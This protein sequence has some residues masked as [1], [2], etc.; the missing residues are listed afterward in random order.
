MLIQRGPDAAR[1]ASCISRSDAVGGEPAARP[2]QHKQKQRESGAMRKMILRVLAVVMLVGVACGA[3]AQEA[4]PPDEDQA[5]QQPA[6]STAE[7]APAG[8]TDSAA[9]PPTD[10][11][12]TAPE[13]AAASAPSSSSD[14][15]GSS[16]AVAPY[17]R[18][19]DSNGSFTESVAIAVPAFHG[20]E[21]PLTLSYDSSHGNGPVG[22]GWRL[23]GLSVIERSRPHGGA[24]LFDDAS[25][26][27]TLDG[28]EMTACSSLPAT[29]P[30]VPNQTTVPSCPAGGTHATRIES[31]LRIK[32]VTGTPNQWEVT[33]RDGTK[34]I[35]KAVSTW[36]TYGADAD[37]V[38]RATNFRWLLASVIDTHSGNNS[39]NSAAVQYGY[40]CDGVP[41]CYIDTIT[42]NGNTIRFYKET[43]TDPVWYATGAGLGKINFRYKTIDVLVSGQRARAYKLSY[44]AGTASGR[45]RLASAQQFGRDATFDGTNTI[46]GGAS[47]PPITFAYSDAAN[48]VSTTSWATR[49]GAWGDNAARLLGDF[50]G[51]G[52]TDSFTKQMTGTCQF[53]L[54]LSNGSGF[55]L[56]QWTVTPA[57]GVNCNPYP[58]PTTANASWRSGDFNGDGKSDVMVF[59]CTRTSFT[60]YVY[61][62]TGSGFTVSK[63]ANTITIRGEDGYQQTAGDFNGD[64]NEDVFIS[65]LQSVIP[66]PNP[67]GEATYPDCVGRV[68]ISTGSAFQISGASVPS[69]KFVFTTNPN[70][71]RR[72]F[73]GAL[74]GDGDGDGKVDLLFTRVTG[75]FDSEG[76][77]TQSGTG[78]RA[79]LG[80]ADGTFTAAGTW[81]GAATNQPIPQVAGALN[82]DGRDDAVKL[83]SNGNVTAYLSTGAKFLAQSTSVKPAGACSTCNLRLGD[84]N[85]D[86]MTDAVTTLTGPTT[87]NF[88]AQFSVFTW[89]NGALVGQNWGTGLATS[90]HPMDAVEID[91]DGKTDLL[92]SWNDAGS[93]SASLNRVGG[94]I[95]DL[96]TGVTSSLGGMTTVAYTPS[97]AWANTNLQFVMQTVSS[98][99]LNDGR[100]TDSKTDYSYA[101]GLWNAPDRR[102]LGFAS[103]TATLPKNAEDAQPP[104]ITSTFLQNICAHPKP[105]VTD[106]KDGASTILRKTEEEY[107]ACTDGPPYK[108]LHTSTTAT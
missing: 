24:P 42:Y 7:E 46:T 63:W 65:S 71:V 79:Y 75:S 60:P 64:G 93:W 1:S 95:P 12:S 84:F 25:D 9:A 54:R 16:Q 10:D 102:F 30:T 107:T 106:E 41:D 18:T 104:T 72:F 57:T 14:D 53:G 39:T 13:A 48:T 88:T 32:R 87:A 47:L 29:G 19:I 40:V 35:Y 108:S 6:G 68:A 69:C 21:P 92:T 5:A 51:D 45:S 4:P 62:S 80:N 83:E 17:E 59:C 78:L 89:R 74:T 3:R 11:A 37:S 99:T 94:P 98:V 49:Q 38:K 31:Y 85:G 58:Y 97:S 22:V 61:L 82:G 56:Q 101:G 103:V 44:A 76:T 8:D 96:L 20:L 90:N 105:L 36:T 86:G 52:P 23:D 91:G 66:P 100:G 70:I 27:F 15:S 67:N 2:A 73:G 81:A 43:R 26:V 55:D 34:L 33:N 28:E 77:F 50:N